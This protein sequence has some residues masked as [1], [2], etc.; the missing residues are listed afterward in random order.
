MYGICVK[1]LH[2]ASFA[3]HGSEETNHFPLT[4]MQCRRNLGYL[5]ERTVC[6]LHEPN[7]LQTHCSFSQQCGWWWQIWLEGSSEGSVFLWLPKQTVVWYW[8]MLQQSGKP[9]GWEFSL[10]CY[11]SNVQPEGSSHKSLVSWKYE[12]IL[13]WISSRSLERAAAWI[14][15]F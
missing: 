5:C 11:E 9:R 15:A 3:F 12:H 7:S 4:D 6:L 14:S 13:I 10:D 8:G 1:H 2:S